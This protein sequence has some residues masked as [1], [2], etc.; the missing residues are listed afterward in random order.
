MVRN[1]PLLPI[2]SCV[3]GAGRHTLQSPNNLDS[4]IRFLRSLP[5]TPRLRMVRR[6][7]KCH[8]YSTGA[9]TPDV[10]HAGCGTGNACTL[11]HYPVPCDWADEQGRPCQY[12]PGPMLPEVLGTGGSGTQD[13][14]LTAMYQQLEQV[15]KEKEEDQKGKY[16]PA[17]KYQPEEHSGQAPTDV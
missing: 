3:P 5:P 1:N 7:T 13:D 2:W 12:L 11:S 4:A 9:P 15:R 14:A 8:R 6:C 17:G 10:D 16:A